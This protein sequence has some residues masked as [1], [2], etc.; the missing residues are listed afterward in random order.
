ML[1]VRFGG[2]FGVFGVLFT[3]D[4][5]IACSSGR[6]PRGELL[7]WTDRRSSVICK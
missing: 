1:G 4:G 3:L 2:A 5:G 6:E 7:L